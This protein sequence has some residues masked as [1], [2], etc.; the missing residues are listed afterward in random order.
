MHRPSKLLALALLVLLIIPPAPAAAQD[1][2]PTYVVQDGDT[3]WGIAQE[4]GT[5]PQ[6]LAA[7]NGMDP[8]AT[9]AVGKALL[10]PGF[11]GVTGVLVT[12]DVGF[13][14]TLDSLGLRYGL[15]ADTL[16]RLNRIVSPGRLYVGQS[17][18]LPQGEKQP[19]ALPESTRLTVA[20][21]GGDLELALRA[22]A[23][24]WTLRAYNQR[25]FRLWS[26]PGETLAVPSPGHPTSA[27]PDPIKS[28]VVSPLPA[29]QGRTVEVKIALSAGASAQ[30]HLGEWSLH[31]EPLD[32]EDLVALQGVH[33]MADP[34]LYDLE[35][36]LTPD[37][38]TA[39]TV[40]FTQP[41]LVVA[42]GYGFDPILEVPPDTIDPEKT[43]PENQ[44]VAAVVAPATP[45]RLWDGVFQFP[46]TNTKSF[47]SQF[48]SRRNYNGTGYINYH[49]GLDFYGKTGT[50]I[51]APAR[52]RVVFTGALTV[53][54]N[55]TIIDHGWGVYTAYLHQSEIQVAVGDMVEPGQIIGLIGDTGRVTGPHLHWEV[56]V[57]GVPVN[58]LEWTRQP[59][60]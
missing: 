26:V 50:P 32:P 4:F 9:L 6:A 57:G 1:Q 31:F 33:A 37:G 13:G 47:P 22:G 7:A 17:L 3:L 18:I 40:D 35:I 27:L 28:T 58:P 59:F 10:I 11:E 53:R 29:I 60:P 19:L 21:G 45:Q 20:A 36:S 24:P 23:D 54:G 16:T 5:D 44:Q 51:P 12:Q 2:G 15:P 39:P 46:S 48:G 43:G 42:G 34:G 25:G 41:V 38:A 14:D 8:S 56:W 49:S 52:G 55:T 30:G